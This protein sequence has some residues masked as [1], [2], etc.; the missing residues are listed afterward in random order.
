MSKKW[1]AEGNRCHYIRESD[2]VNGKM[3]HIGNYQTIDVYLTDGCG[4]MFEVY[5]SSSTE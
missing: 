3:P 4:I 2:L 5:E 1:V